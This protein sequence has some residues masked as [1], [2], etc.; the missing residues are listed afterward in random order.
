MATD[1]ISRDGIAMPYQPW[2]PFPPDAIV[3]IAGFGCG[4]TKIGPAS[5]FWWGWRGGLEAE[6]VIRYARRLDKPKH[7]TK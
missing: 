2:H 5:S 7:S 1:W 4:E 6:T 3:Q